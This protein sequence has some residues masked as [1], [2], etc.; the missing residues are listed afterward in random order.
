MNKKILIICKDI[1]N[2]GGVETTLHLTVSLFPEYDFHFLNLDPIIKKNGFL[3]IK[4]VLKIRKEIKKV[5]PDLIFG[6]D[7]KQNV[8]TFFAG[9][10]YKRYVVLH[11]ILSTQKS[12]KRRVIF[13][14]TYFFSNT[15]VVSK[16]LLNEIPFVLKKEILYNP[17]LSSS[18][19]RKILN[20]TLSIEDIEKNNKKCET[21]NELKKEKILLIV[22]RL[23]YQK[24]LDHIFNN[25]DKINF[26][27]WKLIVLGEG[28]LRKELEEKAKAYE[29]IEFL[30]RQDPEEYYKK[31]SIFLFPSRFEGF[32]MTLCES[33]KQKCIPIAFD[34]NYG[35]NEIIENGKNGFL[36]EDQ[37][38]EKFLLKVNKLMNTNL[39]SLRKTCVNKKE[40][41]IK[42]FKEKFKE[43][44]E[45]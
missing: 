45:R 32:G 41:E 24:G 27:D 34:C 29:N 16:G 5:D 13:N 8:F 35:P 22:A 39:E 18:E 31:S 12:I 28:S 3:T 44:V 38:T 21:I 4:N 11:N 33:I 23:E 1:K 37:N 10:G 42:G 15:L 40:Y 7:G 6:H 36:I 26:N 2:L 17:I 19:T 25:L 9:F 14:I 30:G 20:K 43:L